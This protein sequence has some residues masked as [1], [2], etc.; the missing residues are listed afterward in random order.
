MMMYVLQLMFHE[1]RAAAD[2]P[3][4]TEDKKMKWNDEVRAAADFPW[5]TEDKKMRWN[6]EVRA[7]GCSWCSMINWR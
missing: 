7:A 4:L 1:V 5:L 2:V 3:W 6:D